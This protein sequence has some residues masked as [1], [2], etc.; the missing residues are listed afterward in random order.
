MPYFLR[1]RDRQ[2]QNI[3]SRSQSKVVSFNPSILVAAFSQKIAEEEM[4]IKIPVTTLLEIFCE[5]VINSKVIFKSTK[6]PADS[7]QGNLSHERVK[8][9]EFLLLILLATRLQV[10]VAY[11]LS[12]PKVTDFSLLTLMLVVAHFA[13]TK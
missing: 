1:Q 8:E 6:G 5:F 11:K 13:N 3:R 12:L 4:L 2:R 9:T 10:I 7:W